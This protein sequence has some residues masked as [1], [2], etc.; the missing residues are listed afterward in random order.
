MDVS[1]DDA[2]G[3]RAAGFDGINVGKWDKVWEKYK[4]IIPVENQF[5]YKNLFCTFS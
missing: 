5:F 2:G 3:G 4:V 1:P